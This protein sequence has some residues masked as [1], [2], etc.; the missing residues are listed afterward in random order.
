MNCEKGKQLLAGWMDDQLT[1]AGR[2]ELQE[3]LADCPECRQQA[4]ANRRLW[5]S[6]GEIQAPA[7]SD[8]MQVRFDA[9]LETY[10]HEQE[11]RPPGIAFYLRQLFAIRPGFTWAYSLALLVIGVGLGYAISRGI[12]PV[13]RAGD[14]QVATTNPTISPNKDT[15]VATIALTGT[16]ARQETGT[17]TTSGAGD[18]G[19]ET[20]EKQE[21]RALAD[22]VRE[23]REMVMLA[24]LENPSASERIRGVSYAGDIRTV[25]KN[26]LDALLSTLNNDPNSNV[27]LMTLEALTRYASMPA[28]RKGLVQS[29]LQQDSPL[30]QA[31]MADVMV[32]LQEKKA[33]QPLKELLQQKDLNE[34]V[35]VKI[36]Q[37]LTRLI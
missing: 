30:V 12:R 23:M 20:S 21:L 17:A 31:A 4:K 10:K 28:V 37:T 1:D 35:R 33:V 15:P 24:L 9:M 13:T 18:G 26:V 11:N 25:N 2:S 34:M 29:I 22:Q 5:D 16:S 3:H 14:G 19:G 7:P 32:R 27:R 6:M 36:Q 8:R